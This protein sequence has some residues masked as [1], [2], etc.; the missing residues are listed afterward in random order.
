MKRFTP[1]EDAVIRD[2]PHLGEKRLARLLNRAYQSCRDR[3]AIVLNLP[4]RR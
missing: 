3:R 2:N 4:T 1:E